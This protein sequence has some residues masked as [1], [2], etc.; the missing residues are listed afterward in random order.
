M[1]EAR[2]DL[3]V[4]T[5]LFLAGANQREID[6]PAYSQKQGEKTKA[7]EFVPEIR[8]PSFRGLMRYWL[9]AAVAGLA[10]AQSVGLED[11]RDFESYIFGATDQGSAV[12]VRIKTLS[13]TVKKFKKEGRAIASKFGGR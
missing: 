5:P 6:I 8:P 3:Q 12:Q 1:P 2:F 9:R 10:S 13:E 11:V 7:W 4:V